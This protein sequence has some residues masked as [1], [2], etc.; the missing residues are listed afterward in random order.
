[1]YLAAIGDGTRKHWAWAVVMAVGLELGMLFTPYPGVF[2]IHLS[3]LFVAVTL[4]AHLIFGVVMG[5]SVKRFS[6]RWR[7]QPVATA[8]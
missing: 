4:V 6:L 1:M 7:V 5:L 3:A 2:G 8:A